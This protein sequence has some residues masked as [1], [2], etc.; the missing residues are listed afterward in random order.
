MVG[1]DDGGVAPWGGADVVPEDE[2]AAESGAN[3]VIGFRYDANEVAAGVTEV[4]AYGTA[5]VAERQEA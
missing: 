4:L 3:A 5:V 2:D 1:V